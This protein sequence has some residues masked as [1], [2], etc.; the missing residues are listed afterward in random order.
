M[1]VR[2]FSADLVKS[3]VQ[4]QAN[5]P[6]SG[7]ITKELRTIVAENGVYDPPSPSPLYVERLT[8]NS[9]YLCISSSRSGLF[10]GL[11]PCLIRAVPAAAS[12]F[13]AF[14]ITHKFLV[15]QGF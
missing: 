9:N 8:L 10:R 13:V 3:K 5:P 15:G 4:L 7:Y 1:A 6:A 12:T 2:S 11:T 14:E